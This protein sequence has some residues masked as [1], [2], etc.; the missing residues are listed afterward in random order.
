MPFCGA[1]TKPAF[2]LRWPYAQPTAAMTAPEPCWTATSVTWFANPHE[3][4]V[5]SPAH[6]PVGRLTFT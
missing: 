4:V 1:M 2:V 6:E 3:T 5:V